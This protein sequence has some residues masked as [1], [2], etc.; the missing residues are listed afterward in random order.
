ME[1]VVPEP[2]LRQTHRNPTETVITCAAYGT[3]TSQSPRLRVFWRR[4]DEDSGQASI[5]EFGTEPQIL[6]NQRPKI[7]RLGGRVE[8]NRE[9]LAK[10]CEKMVATHKTQSSLMVEAD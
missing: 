8:D 2:I 1:V 10:S 9:N 4:L 5:E 6:S 3:D 7:R